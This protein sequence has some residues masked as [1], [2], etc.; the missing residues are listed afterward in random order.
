MAKKKKKKQNTRPLPVQRKKLHRRSLI[1]RMLVIVFFVAFAAEMLVYAAVYRLGD[2]RAIEV[3]V[4]EVTAAVRT[5]VDISR[6]ISL[7][8]SILIGERLVSLGLAKGGGLYNAVG[9]RVGVFGEPPA[10]GWRE[11][12]ENGLKGAQ[13]IN[14]ERLE[15]AIQPQTSGFQDVM[16]VRIDRQI[17]N[18]IRDEYV[19]V[20]L[21]L[22]IAVSWTS[23]LALVIFTIFTVVKPVIVIR[24]A[25]NKAVVQP[26]RADMYRLHWDRLDELGDASRSL[27][28]LLTS[29]SVTHQEDLAAMQKAIEESGIGILIYSAEKR[30]MRANTR[31]LW[32]FSAESSREISRSGPNF[33]YR[34]NAKEEIIPLDIF[35]ASHN[36][37][38]MGVAWLHA[39]NEERRVLTSVYAVYRED[40]EILRYIVN[41]GDL[42]SV[43]AKIELLERK[44]ERTEENRLKATSEITRLRGLFEASMTLLDDGSGEGREP[45]KVDVTKL[46][47]D[48]NKEAIRTGMVRGDEQIDELPALLGDQ[49]A[50]Q[51]IF[52]QALVLIHS[53][54]MTEK[55]EIGVSAQILNQGIA[56]YTVEEKLGDAEVTKPKKDPSTWQLPYAAFRKSLAKAKGQVVIFDNAD[57]RPSTLIFRMPATPSID[58]DSIDDDKKEPEDPIEAAIQDDEAGAREDAA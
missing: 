44:I 27:D 6:T 49:A 33:L 25:L 7:A 8:E 50:L 38:F 29:L 35:E 9:D 16:I 31:A 43:N 17:I 42:R 22:T 15:F 37:G 58:V 55:P 14:E 47:G 54:T 57:G 53:V 46:V 13:T 28:M 24:N 19:N 20:A 26:D 11:Y 36:G 34:E 45:S 41:L 1:A 39:A 12:R 32:F 23:I 4:N 48:W 18:A 2:I 10:I 30:L 21:I 56:E 40:G 52:R 3:T 51:S 5:G